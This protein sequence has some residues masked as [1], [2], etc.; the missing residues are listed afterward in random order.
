M[1]LVKPCPIRPEDLVML[2]DSAVAKEKG[3]KF[4]YWSTGPYLVRSAT[5]G[6]MSFVLQHPHEDKALYGTHQQD[7]VQLSM[8]RLEHLRYPPGT[9]TQPEF[10]TN[11]RQYRKGLLPQLAGKFCESELGVQEKAGEGQDGLRKQRWV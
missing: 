7:N 2:R 6:G 8:V 4:Y 5:Q 9:R 3:L 11:L 1:N 10:P